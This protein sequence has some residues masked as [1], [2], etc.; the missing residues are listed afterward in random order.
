MHLAC[1]TVHANQKGLPVPLLPKN[2]RL[3]RHEF[4]VAQFDDLTCATCRDKKPVLTLSNFHDQTDFGQV[5]RH[6]AESYRQNVSVPKSLAD[7]QENMKG[8]GL[9]EQMIGYYMFQHRS[10]K[11]WRGIFYYLATDLL[12]AD[13]VHLRR[14]LRCAAHYSAPRITAH[15]TYMGSYGKKMTGGFIILE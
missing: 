1:D 13:A 8:V 11:L 5:K 9:L 10:K 12:R 7:Y 6:T 2:V 15:R 3:E 4:K 14:A